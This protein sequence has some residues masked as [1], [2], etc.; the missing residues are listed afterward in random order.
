MPPVFGPYPYEV[1]VCPGWVV[2]QDGVSE[3]AEAHYAAE[4]G[5]FAQAFPDVTQALWEGVK[6]LK[7]STA[8]HE[9]EA[10]ERQR[11]KAKG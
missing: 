3:V 4:T 1:D 11:E 5:T 6:T 9:R 10:L 8:A 2:R 7:Q